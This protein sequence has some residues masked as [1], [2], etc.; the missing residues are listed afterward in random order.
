MGV[1]S[2]ALAMKEA[3]VSMPD[4]IISATGY[5]CLEDTGS[6]LTKMIENKEV[7][8]NPTPFIQS[9]HNT[10]GSQIALLLQCQSYNQTYSQGA[11]SF[12]N[13]L[14][15]AS[16]QTAEH[17]EQ[18]VLVGGVDEIT[19]LSHSIQQRFGIFR[20]V[21][22]SLELLKLPKQGTLNGEGSAFFV[23]S[24]K[25]TSRSLAS[26]VAVKALYRAPENTMRRSVESFLATNFVSVNDIDLV[27]WG[28]SGIQQDA[29]LEALD[30]SVFVK[31][32]SMTFKNLCGEYP[33]ASAFA[34]WLG[35]YFAGK[36]IP[37]T[38]LQRNTHREAKRI[39]I[40]NHY[41][42][43]HYSLMLLEAC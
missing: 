15:D 33:V 14:V 23:V 17:P 4:A 25:Q 16:L 37:D 10:I 30:N 8:L 24:G 21:E 27:L 7:A 36:H 26:L 22:N 29:I 13:A 3:N 38:M 32:S 19:T 9:T 39:L 5:G 20:M 1:A 2:A 12:E 18:N 40:V 31:S 11:L 35:V 42:G 43:T 34:F 28:K 6:F 41:F